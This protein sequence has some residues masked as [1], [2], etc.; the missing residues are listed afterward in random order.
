VWQPSPAGHG[1]EQYPAFVSESFDELKNW[2]KRHA[3]KS[4]V[5][6]HVLDPKTGFSIRDLVDTY[7][8]LAAVLLPHLAQRPLTLKRFPDDIHGEAFWEKDAPNF[9]PNWI[10]R[11]PVARKR[12]NILIHYDVDFRCGESTLGSLDG[13]N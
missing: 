5:A 1:S 6:A 9:T 7:E 11:F 2:S 12:D 10:E 8:H 4:G 3:I 13:L